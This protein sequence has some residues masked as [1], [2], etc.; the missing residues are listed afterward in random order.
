[1]LKKE[2]FCRKKGTMRIS[3]LATLAAAALAGFIG[4][5]SKS[6]FDSSTSLGDQIIREANP[7]VTEVGETFKVARRTVGV[8]GAA[9]VIVDTLKGIYR[10]A[11]PVK[12]PMYAGSFAGDTAFSSMIFRRADT[13]KFLPIIESIDSIVFKANFDTQLIAGAPSFQIGVSPVVMADSNTWFDPGQKD[14]SLQDT[15]G[16]PAGVSAGAMTCNLKIGKS[17]FYKRFFRSRTTDS[18][19]VDSLPDTL[20]TDSLQSLLFRLSLRVGSTDGHIHQFTNPSLSIW[21][22]R[23]LLNKDSVFIINMTLFQVAYLFSESDSAALNLRPVS[24]SATSRVAEF[25]FDI[26]KVRDSMLISFQNDTLR[27]ILTAALLG[28]H[29]D[30]VQDDIRHRTALD[31]VIGADMLKFALS[32]YRLKQT[33][34]DT[35]YDG[36]SEFSIGGGKPDTAAIVLNITAP[37]SKLIRT[38]AADTAYLY[39]KALSTNGQVSRIYWQPPVQGSLSIETVAGNPR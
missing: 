29:V 23:K 21:Y 8:G 37:L 35:V 28:L 17:P 13:V 14:S 18:L 5:C 16:Y 19:L 25:A 7:L 3:F 1:M 31:S 15:I 6:P 30:S 39:I 12:H 36:P 4:A 22:T 27:S 2:T 9:S 38:T 20:I 10:V 24:S 32:P 11:D 34:L 33:V 26:S